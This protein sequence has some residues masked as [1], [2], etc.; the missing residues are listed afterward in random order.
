MGGFFRGLNDDGSLSPSFTDNK[1]LYGISF[2]I[3]GPAGAYAA[4]HDE[5]DLEL[6]RR[7]F[8]GQRATRMMPRTAATLSGWYAPANRCRLSRTRPW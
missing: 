8:G 1:Q 2:G 7:R 6:R 4:T 5:A 3:Y